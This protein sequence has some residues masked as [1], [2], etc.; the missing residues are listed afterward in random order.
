VSRA[1][2]RAQEFRTRAI[3]YCAGIKP[4]FLEKIFDAFQ[5]TGRPRE[6]LGLGLAMSKAVVEMH[7]G[8]IFVKE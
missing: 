5:Q 8:K 2:N 6:G 1:V 7:G 3:R 4:Q